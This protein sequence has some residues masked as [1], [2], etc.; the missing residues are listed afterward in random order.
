MAGGLTV[1]VY[2]TLRDDLA[3]AL[4]GTCLT[5]AALTAIALI[6]IRRWI[7][8][9]SD[10]RRILAA[11]QREAERERAR[12]FAAQAALENEQ[13]RL[14]RD[15]AAERY[16]DA[17]KLKAERDAMA[18]DFEDR[19]G[20][21]IAETMEATIRMIRGNKLNPPKPIEGNLIPF[22][23]QQAARAPER[24]REHGVVGP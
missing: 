4:G 10:E 24:S 13:G 7:V 8:D 17:A 19:R 21:L 6:L 3:R 16:A 5:L 15:R 20:T 2:G 12:Y 9:T 1:V 22:P 23:H 14:A 18:A 11:A